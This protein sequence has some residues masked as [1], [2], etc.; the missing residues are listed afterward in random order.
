MSFRSWGNMDQLRYVAIHDF[1]R[2]TIN[3]FT[4]AHSRVTEAISMTGVARKL[5]AVALAALVFLETNKWKPSKHFPGIPCSGKCSCTLIIHIHKNIVN[6]KYRNT[7]FIVLHRAE[8][9]QSTPT[10]FF[11]CLYCHKP[12]AICRSRCW[13]AV[14]VKERCL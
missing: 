3:I 2:K 8:T 9:T 6:L 11:M 10:A 13:F 14:M 4:I 5:D 7:Y 1:L 12:R